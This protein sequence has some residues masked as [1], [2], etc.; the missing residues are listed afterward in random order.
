[1][2]K[3]GEQELSF[4]KKIERVVS[5]Y[6]FSSH[7]TQKKRKRGARVINKYYEFNTNTLITLLAPITLARAQKKEREREMNE[8]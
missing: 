2:N 7:N 1:M 6:F 4:F 3:R 8:E 5:E